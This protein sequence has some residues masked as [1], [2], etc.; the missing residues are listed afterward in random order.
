MSNFNIAVTG[1]PNSCIIK[2]E[3]K[4]IRTLIDT[5]AEVSLIHERV[6]NKLQFEPKL[7]TKHQTSLQAVNGKQ[8]NVRGLIQLPFKIGNEKVTHPFYVVKDINRNAILGR[9]WL[10]ANGVRIYF[11]LGCL[12]IQNSY[13]A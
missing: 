10:T 8:L 4:K 11:D 2:L 1:S 7:N 12:R 9:D 6:Y 13:V 3:N 5:G